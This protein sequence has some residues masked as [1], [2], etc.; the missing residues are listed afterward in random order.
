MQ[1]ICV[2]V[3]SAFVQNGCDFDFYTLKGVGMLDVRALGALFSE[4]SPSLMSPDVLFM[5]TSL[6]GHQIKLST[7]YFA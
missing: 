6:S 1:A 5:R 7:S 3:R 2:L 4:L